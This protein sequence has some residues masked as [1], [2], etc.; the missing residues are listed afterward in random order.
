VSKTPDTISQQI[1][2]TLAVT[3]PGLSCEIGTPERKIIDACS[4]AISEAYVDQ[5]LLGS[6]MD[7]DTKAGLELEQYVG[8]FGFGRIQGTAASGVVRVTLNGPSTTDFTF[9]IGTQFYTQPGLAGTTTLYFSSTASGVLVA[10]DMSCDLPVQCTTVGSNGNLPPNSISYLGD[11]IG[12]ST[13][14]NLTAMYGGVDNETDQELRQRFKDTL[15]RSVA[16]TADWYEALCQQNN[17]VSRV[18]VFGP[19]N[20]YQTQFSVPSGTLTLPVNQDVK[21]AW[22]QMESIFTDIGQETESF[23]SPIYDYTWTGGISPQ[24]ARITTGA[25]VPNDVVDLEFQYTTRCS[26]NDPLN[27]ITNKVDVF[28]D[29]VEPVTIKE[30]TV[31]VATA[32]S[33][34][35]SDTFYT[36]N[37]KRVGSAGTPT[38]GHRFMRLG[39]TPVVSFPSTLTIGGVQYVQGTHYHL[40]QDTT[41]LA[42]TQLETSGIE[43]ATDNPATNTEI[44]GLTYV[45]NRTPELLNAVISGAKQITTDVMVH[46]ASIAY[47]QPCFQVEYDRSYSVSTVNG[48]IE[49]RLQQFFSQLPFGAQIK[50]STLAMYVLQTLGVVDCKVPTTD[51]GNGHYGVQIFTNSADPSPTLT[52][53]SDFK[54]ADNQIATYQGMIIDRVATP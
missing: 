3:I 30:S 35:S 34:T 8:I 38:A 18:K 20:L 13:V 47:V 54:L 43:W 16:G 22:P 1:R 32:L 45:Y 44:P 4:E 31:V 28:I 6:L 12:G 40:L 11:I 24:V 51:P 50:L 27:G 33:A 5:Y 19:I 48:A 29:G 14:S 26:R 53:T 39:S 17:N 37:F 15:L 46:Q 21:Y 41:L 7:I 10:G 2:S 23:Y 42:G 9:N 52:E 49:G 25:M 36:G